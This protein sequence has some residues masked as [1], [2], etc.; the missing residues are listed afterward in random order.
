MW[1]L[2]GVGVVLMWADRRLHGARLA[3][4]TLALATFAAICPGFYFRKHYFILLLPLAG[5]FAGLTM[6]WI[7]RWIGRDSRRKGL[8]VIPL[9]GYL[10]AVAWSFSNNREVWFDLPASGA[11]YFMYPANPFPNAKGVADYIR[12]HSAPEDKIAVLGSEPEIYFYAR[13]H[14]ATGYIYT[15]GLMEDQPFAAA[16]QRE[17]INQVEAAQPEYVVFVNNTL[18]WLPKTPAALRIFDWC[19]QFS[20]NY[21]DLVGVSYTIG[22]LEPAYCWGPE[23]LNSPGTNTIDLF[24]FRRKPGQPTMHPSPPDNNLAVG[25]N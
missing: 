2:A 8:R 11:S 12:T 20:T 24:V 1:L 9:C 22:A 23:A 14:S 25:L 17:M 7:C 19:D 10:L 13:R 15:Y 18:S 6:S 4:L 3:L 5:L 16:M 21:Y